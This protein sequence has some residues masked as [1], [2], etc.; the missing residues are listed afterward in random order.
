MKLFKKLNQ[1]AFAPVELLVVVL[2]MIVIAFIG[3][4]AWQRSNNTNQSTLTNLKADAAGYKTLA[5]QQELGAIIQGCRVGASINSG[6]K[7]R[8]KGIT[9]RGNNR[10]DTHGYVSLQKAS[11]TSH[12]LS[13]GKIIYPN[14]NGS[15]AFLSRPLKPYDRLQ[16]N[17][18]PFV[19]A[20]LSGRD[21]RGVYATYPLNQTHYRSMPRC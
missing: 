12:P 16:S 21:S 14:R 2:V 9:I 10:T 15:W 18:N 1:K 17:S 3:Y 19:I 4:S 13:A 8:M 6:V 11:A 5:Y 20:G 7:I